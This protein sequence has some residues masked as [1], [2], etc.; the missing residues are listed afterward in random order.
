MTFI[1]IVE[2][3]GEGLPEQLLQDRLEE[4]EVHGVNGLVLVCGIVEFGRS[5]WAR[6]TNGAMAKK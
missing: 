1:E 5:A 2:K 4:G 3:L 6:S